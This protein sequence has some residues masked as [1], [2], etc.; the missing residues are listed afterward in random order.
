MMDNIHKRILDITRINEKRVFILDSLSDREFTYG[1]FHKLV[2]SIC[3]NLSKHGL[4]KGDRVAVCLSNSAE[5]AA[6]YFAGLYSG[7]VIIPVNTN[8]NPREMEFVIR[9]SHAKIIIY[10]VST[11]GYI[12]NFLDKEALALE[13]IIEDKAH[14]TFEP[15]AGCRAGDIF[16]VMYTSGTTQLPK[17]VAHSIEGMSNNALDFIRHTRVSTEDRFYNVLSMAYMAGFYNLILLPFFAQ[18]SVVIGKA[19]SVETILNFWKAPEKWKVNVLWLVPTILFMLL[20]LD[21]GSEGIDYCRKNISKVFVGTAPLPVKLRRDF[22]EKYGIKVYENY[23]LSETLFVTTN[24]PQFPV[25]DGSVGKLLSGCS[26][27]IVDSSGQALSLAKEGEIVVKSSGMMLGYLNSQSGSV[28][29]MKAEQG[30][31]TGDIGYLNSEG[32]LF[33][34][35]RKKDLIIRGGINVSPQAVENILMEHE[36]VQQAA[37]IGVADPVYGENIAAVVKLKKDYRFEEIKSLLAEYCQ[38]NLS[39]TQQPY[40]FFEIE[41][42]PLSSTGKISKEKLRTILLEKLKIS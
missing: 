23:G 18:A 11:K 28:E 26:L 1:E 38:R 4:K 10:S 19:F 2:I 7:M 36:A 34:T 17:G 16:V 40:M 32:Y 21:R 15:F 3:V 27:F 41:D 39:P 24:S 25:L 30:F 42:F 33:I 29:E 8:L 13:D 5:F 31:Y 12:N 6:I 14:G 35:G 9:S 20:K 37:V 22:E